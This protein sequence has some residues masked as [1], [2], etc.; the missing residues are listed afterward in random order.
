MVATSAVVQLGLGIDAVF[1]TGLV[2]AAV[3]VGEEVEA[4]LA[5]SVIG[6]LDLDVRAAGGI[7]GTVEVGGSGSAG[8]VPDG[9]QGGVGL[10]RVGLGTAHGNHFPGAARGEHHLEGQRDRLARL[11]VPL[12][13]GGFSQVKVAVAILG[14][15]DGELG[16]LRELLGDTVDGL[17]FPLE[18]LEIHGDV[19]EVPA[20]REDDTVQAVLLGASEGEPSG[21]VPVKELQGFA[22]VS[23]EPGESKCVTFTAAPSQMAFLDE[24]GKWVIEAGQIDVE[25]GA[26]SEDIRLS[27]AFRI[28]RT[29]CIAGRDR[30]F[31]AK[32]TIDKPIVSF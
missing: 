21:L 2:R 11:E 27:S 31:C 24:D 23:L 19:F 13:T 18:H 17:D 8:D 14:T 25:V 10:D 6:D 28:T 16:G 4:V 12:L 30:A 5:A 22:R 9:E 26:S 15:E 32:T 29:Q 7:D 3:R 1:L 20:R